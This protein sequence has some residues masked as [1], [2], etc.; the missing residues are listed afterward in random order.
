MKTHPERADSDIETEWEENY[1]D[2]DGTKGTQNCPQ[3]GTEDGTRCPQSADIANCIADYTVCIAA[4]WPQELWPQQILMQAS[5]GAA[6]P[7]Q[8]R[9]PGC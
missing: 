9:E 3:N 1:G 2:E 4:A 6:H 5:E 8:R 7:R